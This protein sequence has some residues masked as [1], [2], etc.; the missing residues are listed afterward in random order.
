MEAEVFD[1]RDYPPTPPPIHRPPPPAPSPPTVLETNSQI[2]RFTTEAGLS[3]TVVRPS[4]DYLSEGD[5]LATSPLH[6]PLSDDQ[7]DTRFYSICDHTELGRDP[8][9]CTLGDHWEAVRSSQVSLREIAPNDERRYAAAVIPRNHVSLGDHHRNGQHH[10]DHESAT[11]L[12]DLQA[13]YRSQRY[14]YSQAF[15]RWQKQAQRGRRLT[16][17]SDLVNNDSSQPQVGGSGRQSAE[18]LTTHFNKKIAHYGLQPRDLDF[19]SDPATLGRTLAKFRFE[20]ENDVKVLRTASG[21]DDEE[22]STLRET[23][24]AHFTD[25]IHVLDEATH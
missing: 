1:R 9:E 5:L 19:T 23:I 3:C 11:S 2:V 12:E 6:F 7:G 10:L 4:L 16:Y 17:S 20:P 18:N 14:Q 24:S 8:S 25:V 21:I 22:Y 15:L 13:Q